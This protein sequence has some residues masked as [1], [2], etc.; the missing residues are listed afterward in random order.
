LKFE[1]GDE[2]Y[3]GLM[4]DEELGLGL[5][6]TEKELATKEDDSLEISESE[7]VKEEEVTFRAGKG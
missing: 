2:E 4:E 3:N 1:W 5:D 7:E 6:S